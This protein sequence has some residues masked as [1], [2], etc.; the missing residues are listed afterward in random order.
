MEILVI[1]EDERAARLIE[2]RFRGKNIAVVTTLLAAHIRLAG[3]HPYIKVVYR[4]R[5][6]V[7]DDIKN[8]IENGALSQLEV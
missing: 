2:N 8:V 7:G 3:N 4:N 5:E 1:E 6:L